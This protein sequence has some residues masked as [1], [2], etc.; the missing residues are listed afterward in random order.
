MYHI[1]SCAAEALSNCL[2]T[3]LQVVCTP[4]HGPLFAADAFQSKF[5]QLFPDDLIRNHGTWFKDM[6]LMASD[7]VQPEH[8]S[9]FAS[10]LA[11]PEDTALDAGD[12]WEDDSNLLEDA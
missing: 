3:C 9:D 12:A 5:K 4:E 2:L 8:A 10:V 6:P 1:S 11:Q 7:L